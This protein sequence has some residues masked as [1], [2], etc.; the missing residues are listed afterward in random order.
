MRDEHKRIQHWIKKA[1]AHCG[2]VSAEVDAQNRLPDRKRHWYQPDVV[3]RDRSGQIALIVEVENDPMRKV[4]VGASI[5]ADVSIAGTGQVK[6]PRLIFVV[7]M[8]QGIRQIP[9]FRDKANLALPYCKHLRS[10]EVVSEK[11][12]KARKPK[13]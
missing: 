4:I 1:Y 8:R 6:R 7:Y 11:E 5:L 3:V 2:A 9:N 12:F 10:I 13:I